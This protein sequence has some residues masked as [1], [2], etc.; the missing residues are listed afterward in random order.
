MT[1]ILIRHVPHHVIA[2]I[3]E[4]ADAAGLSRQEY[5]HA[6]LMRLARADPGARVAHS[7][8]DVS[9]HDGVRRCYHCPRMSCSYLCKWRYNDWK[10][11]EVDGCISTTKDR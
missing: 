7:L 3:D 4:I 1:D 5:L 2:A 11:E 10:E 8:T 6:Y 9:T